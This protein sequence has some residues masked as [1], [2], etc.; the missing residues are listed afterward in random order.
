MFIIWLASLAFLPLLLTWAVS[1]V[2]WHELRHP[3]I[4]VLLGIVALYACAGLAGTW[5]FNGS[6]TGDGRTGANSPGTDPPS[7]R[8]ATSLIFVLAAGYAILWS[9]KLLLLKR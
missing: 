2:A 4:F 1:A 7:L 9:L 3:W 6:G 8:Y 5:T